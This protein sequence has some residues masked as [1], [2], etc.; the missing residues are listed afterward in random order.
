MTPAIRVK[1]TGRKAIINAR[2]LDPVAQTD[3]TGGILIEDGKIIACGA[4]VTATNLP[5]GC[6][7]IDAKGACLAPGLVD[8]RAQLRDPGFEHQETIETAGQSAAAGGIT[9]IIALPN[10]E[11]VVD[12]VA[13]VEFIARRARKVGLA[14]V[15]TYGAVTKGLEGGEI[16]EMGLLHQAG[17]VAFCDGIKTIAS[18]RLLRQALSYSTFFDGMIVQHPEEPELSKG[19]AM[20]S[21]ELATR[22]GLSGVSPLAEVMQI[23]RDL[24]LVEMTGGRL[25]FAHI[26]TGLSVEVIRKAKKRGLKVT[27][28]TAPFYFALNENAVSD[29]RT[30]AKLSPPLRSEDDRQAIVAGLA[31]GT[32]DAIAS[33]HNPQDVDSK[34]LPFAQAAAGGVG[35]ET[36]LPI[37]L[38]LYHNGHMSM[39]EVIT[40][41]TIAPAG[42]VRIKGAGTLDIGTAADLVLFDPDHPW[43]IDPYQFWSKSKN[44]PFDGRLTQGRVLRTIIDGREV[45][46]DPSVAEGA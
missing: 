35:F 14:K 30:F 4:D 18:A 26:S 11:P 23:E 17:A 9:T 20:N 21:G 43:K 28:D 24:R 16:T 40:K 22:L 6:D 44:S 25:H 36:L 7:I 46:A 1:G 34:R 5:K 32:I 10:T 2:L 29:Y 12:D 45:F 19:A 8:M 3:K 42:L 37:A 15:F 41:L 13:G 38:E 39:L 31:D 33:D 27:C